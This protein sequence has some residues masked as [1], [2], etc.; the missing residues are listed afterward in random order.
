M[1]FVCAEHRLVW[2]HPDYQNKSRVFRH[3]PI[4]C[5]RRPFMSNVALIAEVQPNACTLLLDNGKGVHSHDGYSQE[6]LEW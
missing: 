3:I 6:H 5:C 1:I 4:P 2:T